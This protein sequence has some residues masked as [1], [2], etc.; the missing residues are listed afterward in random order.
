MYPEPRAIEYALTLIPVLFDTGAI[1][2]AQ[3]YG[4][5]GFGEGPGL[6]AAFLASGTAVVVLLLCYFLEEDRYR[7]PQG[8]ERGV[9]FVAAREAARFRIS[10]LAPEVLFIAEKE[11]ALSRSL[12]EEIASD[13]TRPEARTLLPQAVPPGLWEQ[14]VA[15]SYLADEDPERAH[16]E[17][18]GLSEAVETALDEL[19]KAADLLA[20]NRSSGTV[21]DEH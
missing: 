8:P 14:F 4:F 5:S 1:A 3:A 9:G 10:A 20:K 17:L 7:R 18:D 16:E 15:V 11:E 6:V 19:E 21:R 13:G 12:A 2:S